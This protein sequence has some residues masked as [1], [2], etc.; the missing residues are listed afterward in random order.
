MELSAL[1]LAMSLFLVASLWLNSRLVLSPLSL[2]RRKAQQIAESD[3]H[4]GE[5]IP[6]PSGRELGELTAAFNRMSI[7]LRKSRDDLEN[8]V[9]ERTAEMRMAIGNLA[10]G[11]AHDFN[12]LLGIIMGNCEMALLDT[13]VNTIVQQHLEQIARASRR[14]K[15][16]VKQILAFSRKSDAAGHSGF[17]GHRRN[18]DSEVLA[19]HKIDIRWNAR[20]GVKHGILADRTQ[21]Q[22]FDL[23]NQF[24]HPACQ[25]GI[26]K[27]TRCR[28]LT[29]RTLRRLRRTG[30]YVKIL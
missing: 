19:T 26:S 12:N 18:V 13:S 28:D 8:R 22:A 10:G 4:L 14:A 6:V 15:N 25:E 2:I 23:C 9:I 17:G 21:I 5:E 1:F 3:V 24:I 16:I 7:K 29:S 20:A 11:I 27:S 30:S